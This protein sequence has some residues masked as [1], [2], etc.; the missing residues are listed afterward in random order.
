MVITLTSAI[1]DGRGLLSCALDFK[2][3]AGKSRKGPQDG[4]AADGR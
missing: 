1:G 3:D 2:C 4:A